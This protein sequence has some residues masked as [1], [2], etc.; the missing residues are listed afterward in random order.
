M[1]YIT[2]SATQTILYQMVVNN[3][4]EGIRKEAAIVYE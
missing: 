1:A 2:I 4:L 3:K